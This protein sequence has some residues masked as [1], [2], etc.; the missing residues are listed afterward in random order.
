MCMLYETNINTSGTIYF[1]D[2][3]ILSVIL[4]HKHKVYVL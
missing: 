4:I 1:S 3:N 2:N